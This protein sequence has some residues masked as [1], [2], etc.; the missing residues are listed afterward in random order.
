MHGF[1]SYGHLSKV[2]ASYEVSCGA[3]QGCVLRLSASL[4]SHPRCLAITSTSWTA[5]ICY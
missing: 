1:Y 4:P 3:V 5:N 2:L